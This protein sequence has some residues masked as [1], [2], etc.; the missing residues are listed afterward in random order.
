MRRE[1]RAG[2]R[3]RERSGGICVYLLIGLCFAMMF[4]LICDLEPGAVEFVEIENSRN[5]SEHSA[6]ATKLLYFSF[7][8]MTTLGYGDIT[9]R[10]EFA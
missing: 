1:S 9:P 3:A 6:R 4:G 7:V 8:T 5:L 10:G 2:T